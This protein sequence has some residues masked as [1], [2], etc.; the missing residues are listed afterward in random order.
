MTTTTKKTSTPPIFYVLAALSL[1][2]VVVGIYR[3]AT[4][5]AYTTNLSNGVPWGIW[6]AFDFFAV[7]LSAGA[8]TL[9]ATLHIFNRH[10]Y[11]GVAHLALL[12]GWLGYLMV[13]LV[14][15]LD[16]NRWDQFW[17]VLLPWNWNLHS[18]MFE[19][20]LSI[21]LYFGVM[22]L[23]LVPVVFGRKNWLAVQTVERLTPLIAGVG[24]LLS[25]VHQSSI[26]AI[27]LILGHRLDPLWWSPIIPL[28]FFTSALFSGLS[29]AILLALLTWRAMRQPAPMSLLTSIAKVSGI[30]MII[31]LVLKIGDL[32][33]AGDLG[34]AFGGS[35]AVSL[36]F[37]LEIVLI[38]V[39]MGIY[40]SGAREKE[41]N[42]L[43]GSI[44]TLVALMINRWTIAWFAFKPTTGYTYSPHWMEIAI[45]VA[46]FAGGILF[47]SLG[48]RNLPVLREG[49]AEEVQH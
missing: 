49:L 7:P 1:L 5:L 36:L 35:G 2:G 40:L 17:S 8:F 14:L 9:A 19:V 16:I 3:L 47:Y 30:I 27:F 46:A 18:F 29:V 6:I 4:G 28:H 23:E 31:Y 10:K 32:L 25:T 39:A 33:L 13:V 22:M 26:G 42:L 48:V 43:I 12:A 20:A 37:W 21:T 38:A 34:L 15:V 11:H 44:C 45:I 24:V 41:N